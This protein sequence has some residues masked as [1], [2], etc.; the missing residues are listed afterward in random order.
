MI[1]V[2]NGK[3]VVK[4]Q[5]QEI[6]MPRTIHKSLGDF[7]GKFFTADGNVL[8]T[9]QAIR[10]VKDGA[11]ILAA[12]E[13]KPLEPTWLRAVARDT[14]VMVT[15]ELA[16]AHF[17]YG[18]SSLP[19]TAPPRLVMLATDTKGQVRLPVNPTPGNSNSGSYGDWNNFQNGPVRVINRG[20]G[21]QMVFVN[22]NFVPLDTDNSG[23]TFK[24]A[25]SDGK[26]SLE[27]IRFEAYDHTGKLMPKS[28][29]MKRLK[30]GGVVL[31]AGDNR[32]P[33]IEYLK[34]FHEDMIVLV[35]PELIFAPGQPNPYDAP[36]KKPETKAPAPKALAPAGLAPAVPALVVPAQA[37]RLPVAPIAKP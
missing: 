28:E 22:G 35:S 32:P 11:T 7:G 8:T 6:V 16:Q 10:R 24:A 1:V 30:A 18:H 2:E 4:Q 13:D 17:Q 33:D 5:E 25:D 20:G 15:N 21:V 31:F 12:S 19:T 9:E 37:V 26:K 29:A 36:E 3:Q 34:V 23:A 27:D 14:V